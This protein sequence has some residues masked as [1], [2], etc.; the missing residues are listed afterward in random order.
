MHVFPCLRFIDLPTCL[1][2]GRLSIAPE[3]VVPTVATNAEMLAVTELLRRKRRATQNEGFFTTLRVLFQGRP[4]SVT[5]QGI[6]VL[7]LDI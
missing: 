6:V 4:E 2:S 1:I 5:S 3:D 7:G